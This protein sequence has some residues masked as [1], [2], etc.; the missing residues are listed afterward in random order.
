MHLGAHHQ[1]VVVGSRVHCVP[2]YR[3][4]EVNMKRMGIKFIEFLIALVLMSAVM[5]GI[6]QF[7]NPNP[8]D[9][10]PHTQESSNE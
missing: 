3:P 1:C 6:C 4:K 2:T 7:D 8:E 10:V 9:F 5:W